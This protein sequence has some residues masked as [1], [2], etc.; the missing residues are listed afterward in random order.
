[1]RNAKVSVTVAGVITAHNTG[2]EMDSDAPNADYISCMQLYCVTYF[3]FAETLAGCKCHS[4]SR[5]AN[6]YAKFLHNGN[7]N[8]KNDVLMKSFIPTCMGSMAAAGTHRV[9]ELNLPLQ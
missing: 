6:R 9:Q 3:V 2:V 1:M 7:I 8:V 4:S 5:P